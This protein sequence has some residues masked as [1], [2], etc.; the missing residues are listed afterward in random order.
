MISAYFRRGFCGTWH[1]SRAASSVNNVILLFIPNEYAK[2][3]INARFQMPNHLV[4]TVQY[5][6]QQS[7]ERRVISSHSLPLADYV[8]STPL[9]PA[10]LLNPSSW[11]P[12]SS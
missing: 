10:V 12:P 9:L 8:P 11:V 6:Y 5:I 7:P 2:I 1:N 4:L 3:T